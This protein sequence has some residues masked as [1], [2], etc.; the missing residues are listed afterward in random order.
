MKHA[1]GYKLAGSESPYRFVV[2]LVFRFFL[3]G[4]FSFFMFLLFLFL[5]LFNF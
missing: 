1:H 2:R 5:L 4:F 3:L